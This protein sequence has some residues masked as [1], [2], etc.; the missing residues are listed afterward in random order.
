MASCLFCLALHFSA[1]KP[2]AGGI[3]GDRERSSTTSQAVARNNSLRPSA[4][5]VP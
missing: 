4:Q 2:S 5:V 1:R 3:D